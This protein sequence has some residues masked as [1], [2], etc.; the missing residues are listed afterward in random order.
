[1][2]FAK[3]QEKYKNYESAQYINSHLFAEIL[4]KFNDNVRPLIYNQSN[5]EEIFRT[6]SK[7]V[8]M[9]ILNK[10]D[11]EAACDDYLCYDAEDV[12]GMVYYLTGSCFINWKDYENVQSGI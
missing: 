4:L 11:T 12:Y 8:I 9:P 3:K 10:L 2:K 1:M 7:S 5:K 6:V